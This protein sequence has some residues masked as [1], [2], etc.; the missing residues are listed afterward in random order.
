MNFH[1][2]DYVKALKSNL[3]ATLDTESGKE[4]MKFLE[5]LCGWYEF[6]EVDPNRILIAHGKRQVLATIKTLLELTPEQIVALANQ[7]EQ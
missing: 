6:S 5:E 1:D 4:V 2:I 3:R 7:K